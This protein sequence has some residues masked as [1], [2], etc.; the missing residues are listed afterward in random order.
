MTGPESGP[1]PGPESASGSRP[2]SS[3]GPTVGPLA[4][5]LL[6]GRPRQPDARSCGAAVLVMAKAVTDDGYA[7]ALRAGGL[8]LAGVSSPDGAWHA[9]V[10]GMH[11]RSTSLADAAGRLQLPWPRLLGTP[12][13]AVA[14]ALSAWGPPHVVRRAPGALAAVT[15]ALAAGRP[16][17][18][19]VGSRWLPRHVLLALRV[20]EHA[21]W[22]Y[23]PASGLV[24]PL[25]L[26]DLRHRRV[27]VAGWRR[28]WWA[29]VPR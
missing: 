9:E 4:R 19:Y 20:G 8:G 27:A 26:E 18:L 7:G 24:V 17:P 6:E 12:P 15:D 25:L 29:V 28:W 5:A 14:R 1:E 3:L 16:V 21:V 13:W 23:D 11:R 10:L 22:A 2:E